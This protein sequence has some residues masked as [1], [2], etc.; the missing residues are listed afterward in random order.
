MY[1]GD[2]QYVTIFVNRLHR[3]EIKDKHNITI[4]MWGGKLLLLTPTLF[5]YNSNVCTK[6]V[7]TVF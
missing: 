5:T 4:E 6:Y 3:K 7:I 1:A 2:I